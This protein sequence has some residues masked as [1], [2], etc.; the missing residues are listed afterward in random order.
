[1]PVLARLALLI[2]LLLAGCAIHR[3][4]EPKASCIV[5]SDNLAH[6]AP[7]WE[8]EAAK[9]FDRP[10]LLIVHGYSWSGQWAIYPD[11]GP[12]MSVEGVARL[13]KKLYPGRPIVVLSCNPAGVG[14]KL[15]GVYYARKIVSSIP[16]M[17]KPE[18][19][20]GIWEMEEGK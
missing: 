8:R 3:A 14:L 20:E 2:P 11:A 12:S 15:H 17:G 10:V 16:H 5:L 13:L 4:P 1:M 9:R 7:A 18:W 19:A 6:G